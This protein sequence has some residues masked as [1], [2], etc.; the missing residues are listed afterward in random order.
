MARRKRQNKHLALVP[1]PLKVYE[2]Y[3]KRCVVIAKRW[4]FPPNC[5][6]IPVVGTY[7]EGEPFRV[8]EAGRHLRQFDVEYGILARVGTKLPEHSVAAVVLMS[9]WHHSSQHA[10]IQWHAIAAAPNFGASQ[11]PLCRK[12]HQQPKRVWCRSSSSP[13]TIFRLF[14]LFVLAWALFET[15]TGRPWCFGDGRLI[16]L[17]LHTCH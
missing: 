1:N 7:R 15:S 11:P 8:R 14:V 17:D 2:C 9:P 6:N 13:L 12:T 3:D 4:K 5:R 10:R 16:G